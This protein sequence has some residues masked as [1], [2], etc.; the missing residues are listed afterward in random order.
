MLIP[1]YITTPLPLDVIVKVYVVRG[2]ASKVTS[3]VVLA[4]TLLIISSP[5]DICPVTSI[6]F[7]L[8][9]P[10]RQPVSGVNDNTIELPP[11]IEKSRL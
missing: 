8:T 11:S 6:P 4:D 7:T 10:I 9:K 1:S 2:I 5:L 3:T